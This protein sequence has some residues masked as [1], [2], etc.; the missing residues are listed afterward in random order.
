MQTFLRLLTTSAVLVLVTACGGGG[1]GGNS[2]GSGGGNGGENIGA[3]VNPPVSGGASNPGNPEQPKDMPRIYVDTVGGAPVT[4]TED[5]VK[6]NIRIQTAAGANLLQSETE[7]RGRGN[8]TFGYPKRPYRLKFNEA[9]TVLGMPT[10]RDW[11][12][13]ANYADKSMVRT[14]L[15]MNLGRKVGMPYSPRSIFVEFFFNGQYE[16]VYEIIETVEESPSRVNIEELKRTDRDPNIITGGYLLE[17]DHRQ[18]E[19]VCWLT[20]RGIP[21]CSKD[22]EFKP[23]D[24]ANSASG[25]FAQYN[26][27]RN[28]IN[29]AEQAIHTPGNAYQNYFDLDAMVN[30]YLVSELTKNIDAQINRVNNGGKFTSSVFLSKKRDG[31]LSFGP[32]WDFDLSSGNANY[33]GN[34]DPTRWYIR[35]SDWHAPLF[36]TS[37]FGQRV[38]ARW[39]A[40]KSNGTVSGLANE[41]DSIVAG[42]DRSAIDRNFQRWPILGTNVGVNAFVGQTYEEEVNYL[43]NFLTQRAAWMDSEFAREFGKCPGS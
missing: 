38:F 2:G 43:K 16:G 35:N 19:E 20:N 41:V 9:A 39:C 40:L 21:F 34:A 13:L 15:A 11:N 32:L 31:K 36:A 1:G 6:A 27:I 10:N 33:N 12:L 28:Y 26:Y 25:G 29:D 8:T 18:D 23:E 4:N 42:L 3:G 14:K 7:I 5:F 17:V 30:W 22:P 24:I 37:D